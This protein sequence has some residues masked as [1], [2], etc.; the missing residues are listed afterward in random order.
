M[1]RVC[2]LS[3]LT[4]TNDYLPSYTDRP[5]QCGWDHRW[6]SAIIADNCL[7][8]DLPDRQREKPWRGGRGQV[9]AGAVWKRISDESIKGDP[10]GLHWCRTHIFKSRSLLK[11]PSERRSGQVRLRSDDGWVGLCELHPTVG[12]LMNKRAS[13]DNTDKCGTSTLV[14]W[15]S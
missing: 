1:E 4:H 2:A 6:V 9:G 13:I 5:R 8:N 10:P 7:L 11:S 14:A 12:R 15:G 3:T